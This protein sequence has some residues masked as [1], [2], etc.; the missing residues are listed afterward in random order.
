MNLVTNTSGSMAI[1]L[2][3]NLVGRSLSGEDRFFPPVAIR[4]F[5][6]G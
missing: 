2:K 6:D 4:H 3:I 1:G 5:L